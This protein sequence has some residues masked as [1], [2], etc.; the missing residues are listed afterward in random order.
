MRECEV[1]SRPPTNQTKLTTMIW[2]HPEILSKSKLTSASTST[3]GPTLPNGTASPESRIRSRRSGAANV[4]G[5]LSLFS[6]ILETSLSSFTS[7]GRKDHGSSLCVWV[8]F[9]PLYT[10]FLL[11]R[12]VFTYVFTPLSSAEQATDPSQSRKNIVRRLEHHRRP[13]KI[14]SW[15]PT[16]TA[17]TPASAAITHTARAFFS[18]S[19]RSFW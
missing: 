18:S 1:E 14:S 5:S 12:L 3:L 7:K 15:I 2:W 6:S 16:L 19:S 10:L 9:A 11:L 17:P 4:V 8:N 13:E